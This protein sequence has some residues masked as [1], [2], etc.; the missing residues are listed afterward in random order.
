[1]APGASLTVEPHILNGNINC[2][3]NGPSQFHIAYSKKRHK[4][5]PVSTADGAGDG[6]PSRVFSATMQ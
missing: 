4:S 1:M 2:L 3:H 6:G 5:H